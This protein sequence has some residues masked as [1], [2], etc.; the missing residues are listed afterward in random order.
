MSAARL[1]LRADEPL[2]RQKLEQLRSMYEP[3]VYSI[4]RNLMLTLPPW[5]HPEKSRDN[6]KA[7]PWDR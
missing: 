1:N 4:G 6:W 5:R 3:N 7:G 2:A